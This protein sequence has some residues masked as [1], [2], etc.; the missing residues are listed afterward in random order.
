MAAAGHADRT[1]LGCLHSGTSA[2]GVTFETFARNVAGGATVIAGQDPRHVVFIGRN[3]PSF[4][5]L[6]FAAATA[7]VPF[8]PLNYRLAR[9]QLLELLAELEAPLVVADQE[10]LPLVAGTAPSMSCQEFLA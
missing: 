2:D 5:Q 1:A 4:P 10:Y 3:G 8:A 6:L 7:G 9:E